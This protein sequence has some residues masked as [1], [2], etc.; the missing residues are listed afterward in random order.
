MGLER[1]FGF[2]SLGRPACADLVGSGKMTE[3]VPDS[4]R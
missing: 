4:P 1:A 2:L 3:C